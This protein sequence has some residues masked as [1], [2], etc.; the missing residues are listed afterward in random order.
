[1]TFARL[2]GKDDFVQFAPGFG[3]RY[4][5][6][7]DVEE[8]FDWTRPIQREGYSLD[9]IEAITDFQTLCEQYGVTPL[10]LVDWPIISDSRG[11][12]I[13]GALVREGR[14]EVGIQLHPWVNP[15][16]DEEVNQRNTYAGNLPPELERAKFYRLR[17]AIAEV[18]GKQPIAYRAG[19]YGIGPETLNLLREAGV[20]FDTSVRANFDYS[21][22]EGPDFSHYPLEPYWLD[23]RLDIVELPVT[24]V[25]WG[26]LRRQ[27]PIFPFAQMAG[28]TK[29]L[30]ARGRLLERI[31]LTPEGISVTE[32]IR[33]I[34]IAL[35]D[36]LPILNFSFHS[37]S[38]RA[39]HTPYVREPA[40]V[41]AFFDWWHQVLSYLASRDV[42]PTCI[43]DIDAAILR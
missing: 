18:T 27:G 41:E 24:S 34:D 23:R 40:D 14:A 38:L 25:Y 3:Q 7:I 35:D 32:V 36:G 31:S 16:F 22:A 6:T 39:G 42:K 21:K 10:Y 33:G 4:L 2:P 43:G 29:S 15:P 11:K 19:R 1:M 37:P 8:E 26:L 17:D 30:M 13:Y 5:V 20:R 9:T 28:L 12:E